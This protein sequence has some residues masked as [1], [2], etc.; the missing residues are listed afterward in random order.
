MSE[1][2]AIVLCVHHKP[3][4]VMG[5]WLTLI[6]QEWRDADVFVVYNVGDGANTRDSYKAYRELAAREGINRQLSP[7]DERVRLACRLRGIRLTELEYENDHALDSGT[8]YKFIRD[9]LWRNYD[10]VLFLG[11][12]TLLAHPRLLPGLLAF[13][14]RRGVHFVASGHEKRR[15]PRRM[16]VPPADVGATAPPM[17][18]FHAKMI[19]ETFAVF[20]RDPEFNDAYDR[21]G[22][23]FPSETEHHVPGV[24][25]HGAFW[26]RMRSRLQLCWGSTGL[27]GGDWVPGG[28]G[29]HLPLALD[30]WRSRARILLRRQTSASDARLAYGGGSHEAR[31]VAGAGEIDQECGVTFHRVDAPEWFGCATNHLLSRAFLERFADRLDR[32]GMYDVLG[33]PFAGS[34]LEIV[35]GL[36]PAWLG[37][38]KWFTNGLHR[39]RKNFATYQREDYPPEMAAYINRY[40]CGRLAVGWQGDYLT[41][42][43]WRSDLGNLRDVLPAVYFCGSDVKE[44]P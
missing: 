8:W 4:L 11:E 27:T 44:Q 24:T 19:A 38:E 34:A 30:Y 15:L 40:H 29:G 31:A 12:G 7:F 42:R 16:L 35:W 9:G 10:Y 6:S 14:D 25:A 18:R 41:A 2:L 17:D 32:F 43:A 28:L 20:C 26:R 39:V 37:F 33:L 3:W 23:G 1:R 5:T 13:A 21:W 36:L 22:S